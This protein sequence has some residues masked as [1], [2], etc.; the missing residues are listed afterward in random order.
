MHKKTG[1]LKGTHCVPGNKVIGY[2]HYLTGD[3]LDMIQ[4][5]STSPRF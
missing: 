1:E 3:Q 5:Q 4:Y 2:S